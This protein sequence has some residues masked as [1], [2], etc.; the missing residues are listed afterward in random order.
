[1]KVL[2][3]GKFYHPFK[4]GIESVIK[5]SCEELV[6]EDIDVTVLCSNTK[7]RF[8]TDII[9]GVK[10]FRSPTLFTLFSQPLSLLIP[11]FLL[12]W[13]H[14]YDVIHIHSPNPFVEFFSMLFLK[15]HKN[16]VLT[17]HSDIVRQKL[18]KVFYLPFYKKFLKTVESIF[19]PTTNHITYSNSLPK[20]ENKCHIVPF[21]IPESSFELKPEYSQTISEIKNE[22]GPFGLFVGRLVGYK[23]VEILIEAAKE[24]NHKIV[25]VGDGP[26]RIKLES[27]ISENSL[28]GKVYILGR[29]ES[30]EKFVSL[31]HASQYIILP[32]ISPN[33]NFG[34][35]QLEAMYCQK[36]VLTTNLKSGVPAVGIPGETTLLSEPGNVKGLASNMNRIHSDELLYR[37]LVKNGKELYSKKYQKD[38]VIK[39]TL[40]LYGH[41]LK[42]EKKVSI[43]KVA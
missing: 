18:L 23:G 30:N 5:N 34:V 7:C 4:G 16:V 25:I 13:R 12:R 11:L 2:H 37:R 38:Q 43:K 10:V 24:I 21:F 40:E 41:S 32:S 35:V 1:M 3:V 17:H 9:N 6:K 28:E 20:F 39:R 33:E 31:Y 15:K 42:E 36:P 26:L 27:L 14:K 29:V 22:Y 8:E 19:V